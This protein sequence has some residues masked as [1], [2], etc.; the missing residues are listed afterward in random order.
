MNMLEAV[1][2]LKEGKSMSRPKWD[3][4]GEHLM[5]LFGAEHLF[6]VS[7]NPTNGAGYALTW[8]DLNADDWKEVTREA[9]E[10]FGKVEAVAVADAA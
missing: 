10:S 6:K 4:T 1:A 5:W 7:R 3:A 9:M 8:E 2:C